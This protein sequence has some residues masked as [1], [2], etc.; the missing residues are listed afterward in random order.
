M[1]IDPDKSY[2]RTLATS[3]AP[4][5]KTLDKGSMKTTRAMSPRLP[6]SAG[7]PHR[8]SGSDTAWL[9]PQQIHGTDCHKV[10]SKSSL[11]VRPGDPANVGVA[12]AR[13]GHTDQA[14]MS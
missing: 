4:D 2:P 3:N 12:Q 10:Q 13:S 11:P 1:L 6:H 8:R 7:G 9:S 14:H 5:K